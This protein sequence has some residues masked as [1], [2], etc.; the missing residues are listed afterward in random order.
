MALEKITMENFDSKITSGT[1]IVLYVAG[2]STMSES[3]ENTISDL[4]SNYDVYSLDIDKNPKV[5]VEENIM[6]VPTLVKY[7]DGVAVETL[8]GAKEEQTYY[9]FIN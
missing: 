1:N 8:I 3:I 5:A 7:V 4:P 6:A 2:W 9:T